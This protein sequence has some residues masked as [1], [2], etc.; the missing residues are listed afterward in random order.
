MD[1]TDAH[2]KDKYSDL[3]DLLCSDQVVE[4][5]Y[6]I[7]KEYSVKTNCSTNPQM[8]VKGRLKIH[9]DYWESVVGANTVVTS[10]IKESYKTPFTYTP[11]KAYFKNK[12]SGL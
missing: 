5:N 7:E 6:F 4:E 2:V 3:F 8:P 1:K 11:Q 10:V 12:K 9:L